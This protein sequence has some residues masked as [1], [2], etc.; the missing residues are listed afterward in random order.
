MNR[1]RKTKLNVMVGNGGEI[2]ESTYR[3]GWIAR[4]GGWR[5]EEK[6][7]VGVV[8]RESLRRYRVINLPVATRE[9]Q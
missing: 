6:S 9:R 1:R 7:L 5:R 8:A 4:I 2:M 3:D